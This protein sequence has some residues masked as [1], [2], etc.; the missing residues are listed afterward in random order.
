MLPPLATTTTRFAEGADGY[1]SI[2]SDTQSSRYVGTA[3]SQI[4]KR[5]LGTDP[6]IEWR[7]ID[8]HPKAATGEWTHPRCR[9]E[10]VHSDQRHLVTTACG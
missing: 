8:D 4:S 7:A 6:G 3:H 5:Y 9:T 2:A 10:C 1:R